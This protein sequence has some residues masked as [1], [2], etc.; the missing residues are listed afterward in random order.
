MSKYSI[1][2][3]T[4]LICSF[5]FGQ[6]LKLQGSIYKANSKEGLP[7]CSIAIKGSSRGTISDI[8]GNFSF[9]A[10]STD[11]VIISSVGYKTKI[12]AAI[13]LSKTIFLEESVTELEEITISSS[14]KMR[15][16]VI[17][18]TKSKTK[19]LFG[20]SN[21]Y[22]FLLSN[23][24]NSI[25]LIQSVDL[26]LHP[27]T[28]KEE[29]FETVLRIRFYENVNRLPGID[30]VNDNIVVRL[31]ASTKNITIDV[32]K[33]NI[34]LPSNGL[35]IGVDLLGIYDIQNKFIPYN[36]KTIPLNTRIEFSEDTGFLTLRKF[37]GTD[38]T[39]VLYPTQMGEMI[40]VSAKF[41]AKVEY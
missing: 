11:T 21:Q 16:R 35:F 30:I 24:M 2:L 38:W 17:G 39:K 34:E 29:R 4:V 15:S 3:F 26:N 23:Q 10:N 27:A 33:Y 40:N 19:Y 9:I 1:L 32:S 14:R 28:N 6:T 5:S 31:K 22:A 25:G 12:L 7:F 13:D 41:S 37:F 36:V 20:G 8:A 18:N